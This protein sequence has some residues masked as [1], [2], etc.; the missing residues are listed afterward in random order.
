MIPPCLGDLTAQG[1]E[2]AWRADLLCS[3]RAFVGGQPNP[4]TSPPN[5]GVCQ[6]ARAAITDC[7]A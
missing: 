3:P 4:T 5:W 7:V 1:G 2:G 6:Y